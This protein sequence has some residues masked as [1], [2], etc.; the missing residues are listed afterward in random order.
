MEIDKNCEREKEYRYVKPTAF[1]GYQELFFPLHGGKM[2]ECQEVNDHCE[3][4]KT[5][6]NDGN[7]VSKNPVAIHVSKEGFYDIENRGGYSQLVFKQHSKGKYQ[8]QR[9]Q[10]QA[11]S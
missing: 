4:W 10:P 5:R 1:D 3:Q 11:S 7:E 8:G 6:E 9:Q 2:A